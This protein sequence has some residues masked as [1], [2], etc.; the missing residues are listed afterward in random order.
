MNDSD[1]KLTLESFARLLALLKDPPAPNEKLIAAAMAMPK[2]LSLLEEVNDKLDRLVS[3]Q[4]D[5]PVKT[6]SRKKAKEM[7]SLSLSHMERLEKE[8]KFPKR[9]RLTD[10]PR[11]RC[12]YVESEI[13]EWILE[14]ANGTQH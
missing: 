12:A 13:Q 7:T 4:P 1:I 10:H 8:G 11:G 14:R 3:P 9:I 6:I 2:V 5:Q